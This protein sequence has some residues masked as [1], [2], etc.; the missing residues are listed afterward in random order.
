M[1][2]SSLTRCGSLLKQG[3]QPR[4]HSLGWC[5][6]AWLCKTVQSLCTLTVV[7]RVCCDSNATTT[8]HLHEFMAS[9]VTLPVDARLRYRWCAH[10]CLCGPLLLLTTA[11][12]HS[13][14]PSQTAQLVRSIVDRCHLE[15]QSSTGWHTRPFLE[16]EESTH[17]SFLA[18]IPSLNMFTAARILGSVTDMCQVVTMPP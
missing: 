3:A 15:A 12:V 2:R 18:R 6:D 7:L 16:A 8:R 13:F 11:R 4:A 5:C 1:Q 9:L 14:S 10:C 17:E